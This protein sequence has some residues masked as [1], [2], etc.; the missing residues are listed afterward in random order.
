MRIAISLC[1]SVV[2]AGK[3]VAS[4]DPEEKVLDYGCNSPGARIEA[5]EQ[6]KD[7]QLSNVAH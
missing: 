1:V 7:T 5:L 6:V 4:D 2:A 3:T